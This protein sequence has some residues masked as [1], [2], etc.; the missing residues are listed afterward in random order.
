MIVPFRNTGFL[1][2]AIIDSL[3]QGRMTKDKNGSCKDIGK[4]K[5][6]QQTQAAGPS[7]RGRKSN[8]QTLEHLANM[9]DSGTPMH[10]R[11]TI[12]VWERQSDDDDDDLKE[13]EAR[14]DFI[15]DLENT[16]G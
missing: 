14:M 10:I 13:Q 11:K 3:Y 4:G 7:K 1:S 16:R 12:Q 9:Y 2:F 15:S 8:N 5:K 6:L